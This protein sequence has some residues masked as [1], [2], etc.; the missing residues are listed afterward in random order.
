MKIIFRNWDLNPRP[1][2]LHQAITF[3]RGILSRDNLASTQAE[4][5]E[6]ITAVTDNFTLSLD[7]G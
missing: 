3:I 1:S 5:T 6:Y 2:N 4:G 7:I